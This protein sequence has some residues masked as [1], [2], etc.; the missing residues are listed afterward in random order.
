MPGFSGG[1]FLERL[2]GGDLDPEALLITLGRLVSAHPGCGWPVLERRDFLSEG[3]PGRF[4]AIIGN[5]P[6]RVNLDGDL[7]A[8]LETRFET[9]EGEKDLYTFFLEGAVRQLDD[10]GD[11]LMLTSHT[12]LVNH[13]CRK[14]RAFLFAGQ[15][16]RHLFLLPVR[17]FPLAPGVQPVVVHLRR[18]KASSPSCLVRGRFEPETLTWGVER[19]V[20]QELFLEPTGIRQALIPETLAGIFARMEACSV[21]L[22]EIAKVGVGIQESLVR[23]DRVSRFVKT[24]AVGADD[25]P[26]LRGREVKPFRVAW[27]G[28]HLAYGPHLAYAGDPDIFRG[29]KIL[30]QNLRHESLPIRLVATLDRRGFFP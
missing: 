9:G 12:Y 4:A 27:E 14:I 22:G 23:S 30:Y 10:G 11:L 2:C 6:Y 28:K 7:K 19:R 21:P 15:D 29:E 16:L 25:V 20:D 18:G 26:V 1:P 17:F 3:W 5:P 13:Q 24:G 8:R